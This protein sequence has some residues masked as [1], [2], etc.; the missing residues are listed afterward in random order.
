[1]RSFLS[2]SLSLPAAKTL[3]SRSSTCIKMPPADWRLC[4]WCHSSCLWESLCPSTAWVWVWLPGSGSGNPRW[5]LSAI[6][7]S[8]TV[9]HILGPIGMDMRTILKPH[10]SSPIQ[11]LHSHETNLILGFPRQLL[12]RFCFDFAGCGESDGDYISLGWLLR[13]T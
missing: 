2:L 6:V 11:F 13:G 4:S 3:R 5:R 1:M 9:G 12:L 10:P 7:I 8:R